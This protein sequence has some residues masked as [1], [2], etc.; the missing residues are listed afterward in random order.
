M[1]TATERKLRAQS[2]ALAL[3]S[4]VDGL[5]ITERAREVSNFT[6]WLVLVDPDLSLPA[7]ERTERALR[8]RHS[9]MV[10]MSLAASRARSAKR[11]GR[12]VTDATAEAAP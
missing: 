9:H 5:A 2:G 1:L 3:H 8:A 10:K 4:Q 11:Q 7:A 6:R 12:G